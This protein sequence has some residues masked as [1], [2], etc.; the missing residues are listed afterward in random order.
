MFPKMALMCIPYLIQVLSFLNGENE[1]QEGEMAFPR[2][3]SQL[4]A[5]LGLNPRSV[6]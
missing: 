4:T 6:I 2:S 5:E 3:L 1:A